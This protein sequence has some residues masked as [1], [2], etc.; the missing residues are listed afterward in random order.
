MSESLEKLFYGKGEPYQTEDLCLNSKGLP[1][2]IWSAIQFFH[3]ESP[4]EW[5]AMALKLWKL[6]KSQSHLLMCE[7][8]AARIRSTANYSHEE[9]YTDAWVDPEGLFKVRVWR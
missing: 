5:D 1:I 2:S 9:N 8:V 4:K 6:N 3:S 7:A